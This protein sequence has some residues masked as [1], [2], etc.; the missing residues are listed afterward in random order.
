MKSI[1]PV[2]KALKI[3]TA[4]NL[5]GPLLNPAAAQ[6]ALLGVWSPAIIPVYADVLKALGVRKALIVHSQGLD[7]LTPMGPADVV[8][9]TGSSS[10][11]YSCAP[12]A[13]PVRAGT[14]AD[15]RVVPDSHVRHAQAVPSCLGAKA[16]MCIL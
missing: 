9:V 12:R 10:R 5:L 6:H 7:E 14:P 16:S 2:R 3:R 1:A 13:C 8:E 15:R 11:S 4:F